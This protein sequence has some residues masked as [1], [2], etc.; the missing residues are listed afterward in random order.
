MYELRKFKKSHSK[1]KNIAKSNWIRDSHSHSIACR[2]PMWIFTFKIANE[3]WTCQWIHSN[4]IQIQ[5]RLN[6][7]GTAREQNHL[8][9]TRNAMC[10]VLRGP[11][12]ACGF[13]FCFSLSLCLSFSNNCSW[14][15][16]QSNVKWFCLKTLRTLILQ[17]SCSVL[18]AVRPSAQPLHLPKVMAILNM[19]PFI[20]TIF[21]LLILTITM[22]LFHFC[23]ALNSHQ[24]ISKLLFAFEFISNIVWIKLIEFWISR[25]RLISRL[26]PNRRCSCET[27]RSLPTY[28]FGCMHFMVL[29]YHI[30][31]QMLQE[32]RTPTATTTKIK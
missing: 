28:A 17:K 6:E 27:V 23:L 19:D 22:V 14:Y 31:H 5:I 12:R 30:N 24:L 26:H 25:R 32:E 21:I 1:I 29:F 9:T 10:N 11:T 2:F 3:R 20:C 7:K 8:L 13:P 4:H 16:M 15:C 18:P